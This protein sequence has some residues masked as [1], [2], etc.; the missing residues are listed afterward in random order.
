MREFS[1]PEF[2][3]NPMLEATGHGEAA[4]GKVRV[5]VS[6]NGANDAV[7]FDPRMMRQ[8]SDALAEYCATL[9][10]P[11]MKSCSRS[12]SRSMPRRWQA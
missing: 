6:V 10:G 5:T 7:K 1:V 11:R 9:C 2:K 8:S 12:W 3:P 4:D